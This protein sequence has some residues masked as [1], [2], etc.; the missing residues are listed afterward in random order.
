[1][2]RGPWGEKQGWDSFLIKSVNKSTMCHFSPI[3][4]DKDGETWRQGRRGRISAPVYAR[5]SLRGCFSSVA[6]IFFFLFFSSGLKFVENEWPNMTTWHKVSLFAQNLRCSNQGEKVRRW[7]RGN[8]RVEMKE[9]WMFI[10][11]DL[12]G[13]VSLCMSHTQP[14]CRVLFLLNALTHIHTHTHVH[15]HTYIHQCLGVWLIHRAASM[16]F[17][18]PRCCH[19]QDLLPLKLIMQMSQLCVNAKPCRDI[20][21]G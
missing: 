11:S 13:R 2:F 8:E 7:K 1:M 3:N 16:R 17:V 20:F 12:M 6:L 10:S 15:S 5:G 9:W 19:D 18:F 21:L 14:E 4:V